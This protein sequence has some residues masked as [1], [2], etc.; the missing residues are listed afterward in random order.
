MCMNISDQNFVVYMKMIAFLINLNAAGTALMG[1]YFKH[2]F[3]LIVCNDY[4]LCKIILKVSINSFL[5]STLIFY[6]ESI[7]SYT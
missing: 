3:N 2:S 1:E 4:V 6:P 7:D 5:K